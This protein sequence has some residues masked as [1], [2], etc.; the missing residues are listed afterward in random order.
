MKRHLILF[1]LLAFVLTSIWFGPKK[2]IAH[3]EEGLAFYNPIRAYEIATHLWQET[4]FGHVN[5][6][7]TSRLTFNAFIASLYLLGIPNVTIQQIVFF[8]LILVP[9]MTIP[10]LMKTLFPDLKNYIG[11]YSALFYIFNL[12]FVSQ[13]LR[14]FIYEFFLLWSYLPLFIYLW[15]RWLDSR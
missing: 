2:I 7:L 12:F 11:F 10:R 15:I 13:V 4:G 5:P 8:L 6:F 9:L 3:A 1:V 14:R